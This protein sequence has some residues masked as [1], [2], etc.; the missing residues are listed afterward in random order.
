MADM[1]NEQNIWRVIVGSFRERVVWKFTLF[2]AIAKYDF[3][4]CRARLYA[5]LLKA[6]VALGKAKLKMLKGE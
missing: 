4:I 3:R 2:K 5:L 1:F 6:E